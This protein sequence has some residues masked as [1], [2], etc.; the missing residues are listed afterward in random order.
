MKGLILNK[1]SISKNFFVTIVIFFGF[2]LLT[3]CAAQSIVGKWKGVSVKNYYSADYSKKV[4]KSMEEKTAKEA[5][6]SEITFNADHTFI[7]NMSAPNSTNVMTMNGVWA[8][9]QN[10]LM[11]TLEAQYNPQKM[12]T[13][14]T[15][16]ISGNTM[17][18]TAVMAPPSRIIK[19][20]AVSTKI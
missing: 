7:M 12:T 18:T 1:T 15:Y 19:T 16:T 13:T 14:A 8:V 9:T 17:E 2:T 6:N 11:L 10:K 3:T 20:V 4:G 5:G